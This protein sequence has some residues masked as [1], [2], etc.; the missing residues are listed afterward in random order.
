M[1]T[2]GGPA[3]NF[4]GR[5]RELL[6]E[7][8]Q[9]EG[10]GDAVSQRIQRRAD[11]SHAPLSFAQQRLWFL[12]QL[13]PGNAFYNVPI[14]IRS[15][16]PLNTVLLGKVLTE[17]V[18]RHDSLRTSF[19][20][21][22]GVPVQII[23]PATPVTLPVTDISMLALREREQKAAELADEEARQ[24]FDLSTGPLLR[25]RLLRL[26][27][28][29]HLLLLTLHHIISD[30]WS[31]DVFGRELTAVYTA[32]VTGRPSPLPELPVQYPDYAIWQRDRLQ[33]SLLQRHLEY[34]RKELEGIPA[35]QLSA[36]RPRPAIQSFRGASVTFEFP[37]SLGD[38]LRRLGQ[39]ESCTA[40]MT[41]L[42]GFQALLQRYTAQEDIVV[43][44]PVS[45]RDRAELEGLIGF[46]VNTL[47]MRGKLGGNPSFRE[48]LRRVRTTAMGSYAHQ[49]LPF[50][51]L[52]E[53]LQP[54]RD[55][56]RNPLFQ[57]TFQLFA[58][59]VSKP[60]GTGA[61][62]RANGSGTERPSITGQRGTAVFDLG[63]NL[64]E[65]ANGSVQ[66]YVEY[67]TDLFDASTVKRMVGHYQRLLESALATP[68]VPIAQLTLLSGL[69]QRQLLVEWNATETEYPKEASVHELVLKQAEQ[70]P[71]AIA[72]SSSEERITYRQLIVRAN[73]LAWQLADAGAAPGSIVGVC[74]NR[75]AVMPPGL[76]AVLQT[77]AAY[78]PL[79]PCYPAQ[80]LAS[81][82]A[83][84]G[85]R[86]CLING[87]HAELFRNVSAFLAQYSPA[88]D[89]PL[90]LICIEEPA[91][92][93][94]E[95]LGWSPVRV[96][97]DA[98]AYVMYTSG[99]TGQP[100]GTCIPHRAIVRLVRNT[101][102]VEL[103][104]AD[105]IGQASSI[106]FDA[107]TFEIWGALS[108]GAR[109]AIFARDSLLSASSFCEELRFSGATVLFL[110]T[111]L[112]N[113][114]AREEPA[115]FRPLRCLLFG[116]EASDPQ[117]VREMLRMGPPQHILHVYGPTE[118]TTFSTWY[119]VE[120][121]PEGAT[122][123]PLGQPVS[124]TQ[125][126]VLDSNMQLVPVG[127]PGELHLGGDGLATGYL[128]A[129]TLTAEK[130]VSSPFGYADSA[131]LYRT[132]DIVKR[133]PDGNLVFIGRSD[134]QVK[135]R[136]FRVELSEI[137]SAL[138]ACPDVE[139]AVVVLCEDQPGEKQLAAYVVS[140]ASGSVGISAL[141]EF[142]QERLP[143]HMV[144]AH[145][146][147]LPKL[148]LN[149][150]GKVDRRS[151][152]AL[153]RLRPE[154]DGE[155]VAPETPV[156]Q[157]LA[158]IWAS[159]LRL[160]R[161]GIH[162]N[163]FALGGD[164]ILSIQIIGRAKQAGLR[165]VPQ[166]LFRHQTI[167]ELAKV[168]G[169]TASVHAE[170]GPVS[171]IVPLTP[172]QAWFFEHD[173]ADRHHFNQSIL[174]DVAFLA[175]TAMIRRSLNVLV[176]HHDA[177]RMR[178]EYDDAPNSHS[179]RWRQTNAESDS[180]DFLID[181][182]LSG[183]PGE[184]QFD[185]LDAAANQAQTSLDLANGPLL[186]AVLFRSGPDRPNRL[187]LTIHH[188]IIDGI[189]WR[190]IL[191]DLQTIWRQ[192][193]QGERP[194]LP[195]KT[196][197][198]KY[199]AERSTAQANSSDLRSELSYWLRQSQAKP[200]QLPLDFPEAKSDPGANT[201]QYAEDVTVSLR[202]EDTRRILQEVPSV[203]H[204]HVNDALLTALTHAVTEWSG[205][206][207]LLLDLEGHGR[208][209]IFE[210]VDI[211]RT[212]GW[213]TTVFPVF[214]QV[215]ARSDP[216][217]ALKSIKEQLRQI[218][219]RGIGFG[220]LRYLNSDPE[221]GRALRD[222]PTPPLSFNYLGQF[223]SDSGG[224]A[225]PVPAER[226]GSP[227]SPRDRRFHHLE[228]NGS[229]LAGRMQF[230]W[231]FSRR[232]HRRETIQAVAD[233]FARF[234]AELAMSARRRPAGTSY[235][236]SDFPRARLSQSDL[237]NLLGKISRRSDPATQEPA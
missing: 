137:D 3:F 44:V 75:T 199:W 208:E 37:A 179:P 67:S 195:P 225:S 160:Q 23:Q 17:M 148:P 94:M 164:S 13:V 158:E 70:T 9:K 33:G 169:T 159:V 87:E 16:Y 48:L 81:M 154:L 30:G 150:S 86:I 153:D 24:P 72:I 156:E 76:L 89:H 40:F 180:S 10:L 211:S 74:L 96:D 221:V 12:D 182:D 175:G 97:P 117:T 205:E 235:T 134:H 218:P 193:A 99:S 230:T 140:K 204:T 237:D 32:F 203:Y 210:D 79:D 222:L 93:G 116:G 143:P 1:S 192:L 64:W 62:T 73:R 6:D 139:N 34:W 91:E 27:P 146:V 207:G 20:L 128:N 186:R 57:V 217:A 112:F 147:F 233:Q 104:A 61:P 2:N 53:E 231:T 111:A 82:I 223:G 5:R 36:D 105:T 47:V 4:T 49:E 151:L 157:L 200:F 170:Q 90:Q 35:L 229:V 163:F 101:N 77:G 42:A 92:T 80:R 45:G 109:L 178:F 165:L 55:L 132:G 177:L 183:T 110:T 127:V 83:D 187:L 126:F 88:G 28:I 216:E 39:S 206:A 43:G 125:C 130:F 124:N 129:P 155:Y 213:F 22:D 71:D 19:G 196:T 149:A 224:T 188:L 171:G 58:M 236:P 29:D 121:V 51:K 168:A 114:L 184:K 63:F 227:T 144:P 65:T 8:A 142:L 107:A 103:S 201:V 166:Q 46:F 141:R 232:L 202:P 52:V 176:E 228:V 18:R 122:T 31:L 56:S 100:K 173:L 106:S 115:I 133:L 209:S 26:G 25:C 181:V 98:L 131:K 54:E 172:V 162:D 15:G 167:A 174:L 7:L 189:S 135:I 220:L 234:L 21:Q 145:F 102:Y 95:D 226:G 219:N 50:E 197:S 136:G 68:E 161:V 198:F 119:R 60:P 118:N 120:G 14:S 84:S 191:E 85:S 41:F 78:L 215:E 69:E 38:G 66:G 11:R 190:I 123:V 138:A 152:P 185:I 194:Q 214:L 59:G 113:Q 212:V 108:N